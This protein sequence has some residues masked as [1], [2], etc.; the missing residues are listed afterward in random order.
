MQLIENFTT[1]RQKGQEK[2]QAKEGLHN[3]R[4]KK[5][6]DVQ[7]SPFCKLFRSFYFFAITGS[8][9]QKGSAAR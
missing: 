1:T 5:G 7:S 2:K 9:V 8:Y 4:N 6:D 3:D